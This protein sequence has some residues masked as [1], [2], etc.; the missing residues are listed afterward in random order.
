MI[1]MKDGTLVG[2]DVLNLRRVRLDVVEAGHAAPRL[3]K[4]R[5]AGRHLR[6]GP[7]AHEHTVEND[8]DVSHSEVLHLTVDEEGRHQEG[9]SAPAHPA[10]P[11]VAP[12]DTCLHPG[13]EAAPP[14]QVD[15]AFAMRQRR[16]LSAEGHHRADGVETTVQMA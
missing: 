2:V 12:A 11:E 9:P 16:L 3:G 14:R 7:A 1:S 6:H 15:G 10:G 13:H 5:E 8:H 4:A